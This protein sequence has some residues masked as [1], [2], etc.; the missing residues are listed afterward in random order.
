MSPNRGQTRAEPMSRTA[1][2]LRQPCPPDLGPWSS[3]N[4][5]L[6]ADDIDRLAVRFLRLAPVRD[7][8]YAM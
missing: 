6:L 7:H 8:G 2:W 1:W 3:G 4:V 5:L